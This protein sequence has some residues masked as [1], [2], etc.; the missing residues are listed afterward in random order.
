MYEFVKQWVLPPAGLWLVIALGLVAQ[1]WRP[2][3]GAALAWTG[4]AVL[5][6][7][8]TPAFGKLLMAWVEPPP[9]PA[10]ERFDPG[11]AQAIVVLSAGVETGQPDYGG[12]TADANTLER[13]RAAVRLHRATGLP[14]LVTGGKLKHTDGTVAAVMKEALERDFQVPVRWVEDRSTT[15]AENATFSAEM[16]RADG[17]DTVMLVTHAFH[18]RRSAAVFE[19]AGLGVV[20]APT[21]YASRLRGHLGEFMPS[22]NGLRATHYAVYELIGALWYRLTGKY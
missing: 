5:Y 9:A 1:R 17:I 13:L 22:M 20:P 18:M 12:E 11:P 19:A 8:A 6:V 3:A 2:R 15:T 10:F 16:L 7:A 14:I 4:L 21:G